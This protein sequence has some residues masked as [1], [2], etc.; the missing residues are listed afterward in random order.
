MKEMG[1]EVDFL[2]ADKHQGTIFPLIGLIFFD[3]YGQAY[4]NYPGKLV[5]SL[6]YLKKQV[7][8]ILCV[9][10]TCIDLAMRFI[11]LICQSKAITND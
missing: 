11:C 7:R 9:F 3:G 5:I 6:W 10:G 2:Y 4:P 1:D 8:S